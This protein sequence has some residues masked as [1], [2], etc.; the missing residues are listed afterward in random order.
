[1]TDAQQLENAVLNLAL[2]ARDA[3]PEGGTL[4]IRAT[5]T[6]LGPMQVADFDVTPGCYVALS[7][8]DTGTGMD[9]ATQ[10]RASEPFFTT[11]RFG[12]GSGLGLSMVYGFAKQSGGGIRIQS[13]LGEGCIVTMVLP[14][15][16]DGQGNESAPG[17]Q[18][19][20]G[21]QTTER[22]LVLLVED[23]PD[24]RRVIRMQL[25]GLGYPVMEADHA[26]DALLLLA[27]VPTVGILISD[28]VMPGGMDGRALCLAASQSAP[29]VK[30]LVIS[31]YSDEYAVSS[32]SAF[33]PPL[34]KKPFTAP[35]LQQ[36]LDGLLA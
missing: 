1:M 35:E 26:A 25:V 36:A 5:R 16:G 3:M 13:A 21:R 27:S 30:A 7:V 31:G 10:A 34:L 8:S 15:T 29:H 18:H 28:M 6:Y 4:T 20:S 24:V 23:D 9:A 17:V 11:K 12:S 19:R 2:N 33:G 32:D 14:C 22:P